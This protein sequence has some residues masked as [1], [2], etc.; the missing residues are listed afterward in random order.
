MNGDR[1][2]VS[3]KRSFHNFFGIVS[4]DEGEGSGS[5][6]SYSGHL[7]KVVTEAMDLVQAGLAL[8]CWHWLGDDITFV[9][10]LPP[11]YLHYRGEG[12]R[13]HIKLVFGRVKTI[14][15]PA[16]GKELIRRCRESD[17]FLTEK[18]VLRME[19]PLDI[20]EVSG[21]IIPDEPGHIVVR[22]KT[23]QWA[24]LRKKPGVKSDPESD[25]ASTELELGVNDADFVCTYAFACN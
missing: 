20:R 2:V 24:G 9:Y 7:Q 21:V 22:F 10:K 12:S 5:V 6:E 3:L 14:Y 11:S 1:V 15:V 17:F 18:D 4:D 13:A 25:G 23:G 8:V 16:I 19:S